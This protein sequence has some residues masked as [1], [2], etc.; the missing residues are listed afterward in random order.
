MPKAT[1]RKSIT[2]NFDARLLTEVNNLCPLCGKRL[3]GEKN[4]KS[5]KLYQVAHIYPHSPT[6]EQQEALKTVPKEA[7]PEGF[8][9][10]IALCYDCHTKQDF[11]TTAT[12]YTRLYNIKQNLVRETKAMDDASTIQIEDQIHDILRKLNQ[13]DA[14]EMIPL[15]YD[16]V[17]LE[18]K[19][20]KTSTLLLSK[21]RGM[22]VQYYPFV[23]QE[24]AR[25]DGMGQ[26]KFDQIATAVK[27]SYLKMKAHGLS[28]QTSFDQL[29]RWLQ[30]KTQSQYGVA[31]EVVV[32]FFVQNCE[33]FDATS[34]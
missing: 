28:H 11:H 8:L 12:E 16:P 15:S 14:G 1:D 13:S 29:V 27:A 33:V 19:I 25:L 26:V 31:C 32:A 7:D 23:A 6:P 17:V 5:V 21:V 4:G 24:F 10:L 2:P 9:N 20:P 30:S 18:Q 34:K 3:L 22:V